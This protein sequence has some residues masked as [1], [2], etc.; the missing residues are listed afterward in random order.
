MRGVRPR[1]K[2]GASDDLPVDLVIDASGHGQ[3]TLNLVAACGLAWPSEDTVGIDMHYATAMFS[4]P[5]RLAADWKVLVTYPDP[6][7]NRRGAFVLPVENGKWIVTLIGHH[8]CKSPTD[9]AG[10]R[11]YTRQLPTST[12][13]DLLQTFQLNP[14]VARHDL[15]ASRW[16]HFESMERL[17]QKLVPLAILSVGSI[18]QYGQGMTVA[19][20]EA[21]LLRGLLRRVADGNDTLFEL[22]LKFLRQCQSIIDVAWGTA[23][24]PDFIDPLTE[25]RPPG[26]I[27]EA[28][29]FQLGLFKL[30]QQNPDVHKL[31]V[32]VQ[33][34]LR[35]RTEL[36]KPEIVKRVQTH[37]SV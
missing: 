1:N 9:L 28:L 36:L 20:K 33:H 4:G 7:Q 16:R 8:N 37:V 10:F 12:V 31:M 3:L 26:N 30:A 2:T 13:F 29:A 22:S 32:E 24:V 5:P 6:P 15:R 11:D 21:C 19:A 34:M 27:K 14:D 23:V 18:L 17:P 25:G 35:P